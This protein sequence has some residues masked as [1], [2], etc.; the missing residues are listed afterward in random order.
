MNKLNNVSCET[1]SDTEQKK[2]DKY[3]KFLLESHN[4]FYYEP[5][6]NDLIMLTNKMLDLDTKFLLRGGCKSYWKFVADVYQETE[7]TY[8]AMPLWSIL[9]KLPNASEMMSVK[10]RNKFKKLPNRFDV[11]RGGVSDKHFS[12]TTDKDVAIWFLERHSH[13]KKITEEYQVEF[14]REPHAKLWTKTVNKEDCICYF[15]DKKESEI[16]IKFWELR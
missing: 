16:L 2:L 8:N 6:P 4:K 7:F 3:F 14:K 15:G 13:F 10:D 11:Y 9:L 5:S 1:I 12:W